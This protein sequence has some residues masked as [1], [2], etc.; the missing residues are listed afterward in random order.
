MRKDLE[1]VPQLEDVFY[2][3]LQI[4]KGGISKVMVKSE[5]VTFYEFKVLRDGLEIKSISKRYSE[6]EELHRVP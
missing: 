1:L 5:C 4:V 6:I 2:I 3:S